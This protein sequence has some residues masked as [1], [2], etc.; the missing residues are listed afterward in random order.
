MVA[1][2]EITVMLQLDWAGVEGGCVWG[3]GGGVAVVLWYRQH[4]NRVQWLVLQMALVIK[5]V[6]FIS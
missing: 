6:T 5:L 2:Y 3:G 4:C 1:T